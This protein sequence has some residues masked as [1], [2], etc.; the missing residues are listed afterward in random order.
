[1]E[2]PQFTTSNHSLKC[3]VLIIDFILLIFYCYVPHAV[4]VEKKN[5][6]YSNNK[7]VSRWRKKKKVK[8]LFLVHTMSPRHTA[9]S[10]VIAH[11]K[12]IE[13]G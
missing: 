11:K 6:D 3:F 7:C 9:A 10:S 4:Q 2:F 8:C 13:L 1:M 12:K 5:K